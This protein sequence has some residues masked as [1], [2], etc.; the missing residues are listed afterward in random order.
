MTAAPEPV[1][2]VSITAVDL[3]STRREPSGG[4]HQYR[5][6]SATFIYFTPAIAQ[7][8]IAELSTIKPNEKE[9]N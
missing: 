9:S 8:W 2:G 6:G 7:Q 4:R 1:I 3:E 5:I